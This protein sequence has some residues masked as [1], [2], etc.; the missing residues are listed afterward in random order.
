MPLVA[1]PLAYWAVGG[2]IVATGATIA[3]QQ[4]GGAEATAQAIDNAIDGLTS[5]ND[6]ADEQAGATATAVTC[7][8]CAQNP[9]AHLACG[10]PG[11][12]YRGGAHGCM[13]QPT[14]DGKDSH[15]MPARSI[16]PVHPNVGPS[17]QMDPID[18]RRTNSYG[19]TPASNA[20]LAGQQDMVASG[21]FIGAQAIDVAE[22]LAKFPGKYD[23]AIIQMEAYT[24]CLKQNGI[25]R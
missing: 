13:T 24:A 12:Q 9:C 18:H 5:S 1:I 23:S 20:V 8:T 14:G 3:W 17:I 6:S 10:A 11:S 21:N 19:A 2:L 15:H 16:S 7:A 4:S 22:V 25:V